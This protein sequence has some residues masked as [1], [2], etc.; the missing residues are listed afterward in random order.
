M[1]VW[2]VVSMY[3]VVCLMICCSTEKV[4]IEEFSKEKVSI[5]DFS[6]KKISIEEYRT[7]NGREN[8]LK[9]IYYGSTNQLFN[10]KSPTCY[11]HKDQKE[12]LPRSEGIPN[13]RIISNLLS[14]F[15]N[16]KG[17]SELS[18]IDV[19]TLFVFWGQFTDHDL[20]LA[21]GSDP[22]D[23]FNI[24]IKEEDPDY[25]TGH[26]KFCRSFGMNDRQCKRQQVNT[27]TSWLD[28]SQ[29][30]G[31]STLVSN[32]L[33]LFKN[34]HMKTL[35]T[36]GDHY[37]PYNVENIMDN[38]MNR[39]KTSELGMAGD[40]RANENIMLYSIHVL[41]VR[42][43]NRIATELKSKYPNWNDEILF[44]E[45]RKRVVALLQKITFYDWLPILLG[46]DEMP[47]YSGYN[48]NIDSTILNEF[49]TIAFRFGHS[50]LSNQ[51]PV[52]D[53]ITQEENVMSLFD[54]FF[55]PIPAIDYYGIEGFLVSSLF[56][57]AQSIDPLIVNDVRNRL[58]S[59]PFNWT[60]VNIDLLAT[61]LQRSDDH[62]ICGYNILR[63]SFGLSPIY[64]MSL[65]SLLSFKE[66][67]DVMSHYQFDTNLLHGFVGG[68]MEL[69]NGI[70][71]PLF[72]SIIETQFSL[73]RDGDRFWFE[74][75]QFNTLDLNVIKSTTL[76]DII[77]RNVRHLEK[78]DLKTDHVFQTE[79]N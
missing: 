67:Q 11:N 12:D 69:K 64:N 78:L 44:Q 66:T 43:H 63:Q 75:D 31:S 65:Y 16:V 26:M 9:H 60:N 77:K 36:N 32:Y 40:I 24:P 39:V 8:N 50:M 18:Q 51:V 73:L 1:N 19:N 45:S 74:N 46:R 27:V 53:P 42:E 30:Y 10:R 76:L 58:F 6:K 2:F 35:F 7:F 5:E 79:I 28:G 68:L 29:I 22:C 70:L 13:P 56:Q 21:L 23:S 59:P 47:S 54:G 49:S 48:D 17:F 55:N 20:A 14:Q 33:R 61:N 25:G 3:I 52:I 4:S 41:F 37:L 71:G 34:G 15:Y 62:G 57:R 38:P 72:S